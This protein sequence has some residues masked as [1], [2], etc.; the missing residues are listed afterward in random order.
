MNLE[1]ATLAQL[2]AALDSGEVSAERL[3][4]GYL[5]RIAASSL[6]AFI[7]VQPGLTLAQAREA[8]AR[9]ARGERAPLLGVPLAHKDIFVTRGWRAR[10]DPAS[11]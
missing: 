7:D 2:R 10:R 11:S 5:E 1:A 3:A 8:D 6:N 4:L 9:L